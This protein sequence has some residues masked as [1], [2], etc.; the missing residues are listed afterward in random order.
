MILPDTLTF[1]SHIKLDMILPD[2]LTFTSRIKLDMILPDTLTSTSRIKL[3]VS[4]S[5]SMPIT[6]GP[7]SL[8]SGLTSPAPGNWL[9]PF[10]CW[11]ASVSQGRICSDNGTCCHTEAE[12]ADQTFYLTQSQCTDTGPTSPSVA[13][14]NTRRL[15]GQ[16]L[17]CQFE[18]H[19]YDSTQKNPHGASGIQT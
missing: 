3:A 6:A 4:S 10:V 13:P 14:Y 18:S 19:W 7:T 2:T 17:A 12:V 5:H 11:S 15:A 1:T 8:S 16:P 9:D